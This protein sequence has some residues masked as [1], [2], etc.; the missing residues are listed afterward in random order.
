MGN[1]STRVWNETQGSK[2]ENN[3]GI[4][5]TTEHLLKPASTDQTC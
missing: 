1:S 5:A 4:P 2:N 3:I